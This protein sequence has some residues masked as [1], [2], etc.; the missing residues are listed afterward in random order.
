MLVSWLTLHN[1]STM[2][3]TKNIKYIL[4]LTYRLRKNRPE[5]LEDM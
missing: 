4:E 5:I 2:H 1:C 3:G